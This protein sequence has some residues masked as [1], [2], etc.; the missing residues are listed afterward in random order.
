VTDEQDPGRDDRV[1]RRKEARRAQRLE[2]RQRAK[3]AA[4]AAAEPPRA[5]A[6]SAPPE[7]RDLD[8]RRLRRKWVVPVTQPMLLISQVPRSGGTLLGRLFD[9]HPECFAHPLELRWGDPKENWPSFEADPSMSA[10]EAH[11]LLAEKWQE[12]FVYHGGYSKYSAPMRSQQPDEAVQ[13][14]F[15]YDAALA[16]DIFADAYRREGTA[17]RRAV[18]N[19][20]L[21]S[22]FNGWLDYQSLYAAPK[23]WV[24]CFLPTMVT[25]R[26]SVER[27]FAD[28]PD[29]RLITMVR[30]PGSWFASYAPFRQHRGDVEL[31]GSMSLWLDSAKA[32]FDALETYGERVTI[33]LFE[34]LVLRTEAVMRALCARMEIAFDPLLL[35]PTYN[36]MPVLSDSSFRLSA[37]IDPETTERH[38]AKLTAEQRAEI[39]RI[40]TPIYDEVVRRFGLE[41]SV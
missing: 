26:G 27:F 37:T 8:H 36:G 23:R 5:L 16:F 35:R 20:H 28:Y 2:S 19:A 1:R 14:P 7:S 21:T 34:D 41:Q 11:A 4:A 12:R 10:E 33:L 6:E 25:V 30:H 29:G 13:Y 38:H 39:D 22:L 17:T 18:L 40:A 15:V 9:G 3:A 24:T 31:A 32:G